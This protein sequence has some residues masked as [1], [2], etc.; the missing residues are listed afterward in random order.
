MEAPTN[1]ATSEVTHRSFRATWTPPSDPVDKYRVMYVS[2]AGEPER[3]VR[4][5]DV[6]GP[7]VVSV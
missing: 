6:V 2:V 4:L 3:E 5:Q 1:L 7:R